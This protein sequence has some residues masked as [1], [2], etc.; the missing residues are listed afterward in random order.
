M[1]SNM[2]LELA[3]SRRQQCNSGERT[4]AS[5]RLICSVYS[6]RAIIIRDR[7][8]AIRTQLV[9]LLDIKYSQRLVQMPKC[10]EN[11]PVLNRDWSGLC[12]L[13]S[14]FVRIQQFEQMILAVH[15]CFNKRNQSDCYASDATLCSC[16]C[17]WRLGYSKA[18]AAVVCVKTQVMIIVN[19][20][21][22]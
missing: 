4:S 18:T 5:Q 19:Y 17:C 15:Q 21:S 14:R 2:R 8:V 10:G 1:I 11:S 9:H 3:M 6:S 22:F 13:I 7:S 12:D 16:A 20:A